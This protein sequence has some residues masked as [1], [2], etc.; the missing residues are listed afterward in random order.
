MCISTF[1]PNINGFFSRVGMSQ[2][3]LFQMF[4]FT[5][6]IIKKQLVTIENKLRL[7]TNTSSHK[8]ALR[9]LKTSIRLFYVSTPRQGHGF[10]N[11]TLFFLFFK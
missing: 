9:S 11:V 4:F 6:Q 5:D 2:K 3:S 10:S 7:F 8:K 1:L